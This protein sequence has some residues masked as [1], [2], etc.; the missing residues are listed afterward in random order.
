MGEAELEPKLAWSPK[1][2]L[3]T[4]YQLPLYFEIKHQER[5]RT[6]QGPQ[7]PLG[8]GSWARG[9]PFNEGN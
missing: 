4:L 6:L 3:A 1:S 9:T 5:Y 2:V 8:Q 7:G